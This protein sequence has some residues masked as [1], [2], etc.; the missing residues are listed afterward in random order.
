MNIMSSG[1]RFILVITALLNLCYFIFKIRK[2]RMQI[3]Y[4]IF[5]SLFSGLLLLLAMF[6]GVVGFAS[7]ML[8]VVSPANLVFLVVI[9]VLILRLF[10]VTIKLSR[11]DEQITRLTQHIAILEKDIENKNGYPKGL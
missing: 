9:F 8:G 7:N 6:P 10:S 11:M 1:L 3:E 4:A 2:N 5:W